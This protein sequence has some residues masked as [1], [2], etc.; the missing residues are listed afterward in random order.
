MWNILYCEKGVA[1]ENG[2]R[3]GGLTLSTFCAQDLRWARSTQK[4]RMK[5][6]VHREGK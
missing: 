5:K 3:S 6:L 2:Q 1:E 4:S